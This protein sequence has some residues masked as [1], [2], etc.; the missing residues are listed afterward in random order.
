MGARS[1][2]E[3]ADGA[4]ETDRMNAWS[5]VVDADGAGETDRM[6]AR[7][8]VDIKSC[9][10]GTGSALEAHTKFCDACTDSALKAHKEDM[11]G[12]PMSNVGSR[13]R[14]GGEVGNT[15]TIETTNRRAQCGCAGV[16]DFER[17]RQGGEVPRGQRC[18]RRRARADGPESVENRRGS[19]VAVYRR[20]W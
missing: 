11:V 20:G 18:G 3:D 12:V 8:V 16:S 10:A 4:G 5:E 6:N 14:R 13:A 7:S 9:S 1:E 2:V 19:A 17:D 15:R